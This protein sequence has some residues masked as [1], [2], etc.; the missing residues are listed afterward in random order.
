MVAAAAP[1]EGYGVG[2]AEKAI[3][4]LIKQAA[5]SKVFTPFR[6]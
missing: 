5:G 1:F 4:A 6:G 3:K 2:E